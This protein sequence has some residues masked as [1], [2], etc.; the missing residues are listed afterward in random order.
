MNSIGWNVGHLA[1]Q[2]QRYFLDLAQGRVLF[3]EIAVRFA[4]G[5]PASTPRLYEV[6]EQWTAITAA[7]DPWL[8]KLTVETLLAH[9]IRR[10]RA[11]PVS[12][13]SLLLRQIYHYW[14]HNGENQAVRQQL[15][16]G[17]LAQ[18]VGNI[19][20]EAPYRPEGDLS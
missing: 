4:S 17:D 20:D 6:L 14:Y 2:E 7:V 13:G 9:P 11:L 8:E 10:G 12:F 19:D 1:W 15:G 16:H 5:A 18:F 3:P